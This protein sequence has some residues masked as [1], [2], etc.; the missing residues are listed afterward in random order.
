M[1]GINDDQVHGMLLAIIQSKGVGGG[2]ETMA[3]RRRRLVIRSRGTPIPMTIILAEHVRIHSLKCYL[4]PESNAINIAQAPPRWLLLNI[5][6][7]GSEL[8]V[9]LQW[10]ERL[11][12]VAKRKA[13][14]T[15]Q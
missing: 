6:H 14:L 7:I 2:R 11:V 15:D 9:L 4:S 12:E 13:T 3:R 1:F 5:R 8:A 10:C